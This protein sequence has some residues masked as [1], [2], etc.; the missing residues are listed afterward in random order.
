LS[1]FHFGEGDYLGTEA[2]IQDELREQDALRDLPAPLEPLRATDAPGARVM[3]PSPEVFPGGSWERPWTAGEDGEELE[4]P[5]EAGSAHATVEG[6]GELAIELDGE[7][8]LPVEVTGA[9]L[10]DLA[11]HARHETHSLLLRPS[12]GLRVWS[13]SY[14]AGVP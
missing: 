14:G 8:L 4:L 2:A 7:A 13:V 1:W 11:E 9:S 10:Y 5:Y 3:A 12:P 6:E